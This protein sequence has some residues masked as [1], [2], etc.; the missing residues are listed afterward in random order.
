[1]NE[2]DNTEE[3]EET[4]VVLVPNEVDAPAPADIPDEIDM[5][6][7]ADLSE[8]QKSIDDTREQIATV[9]TITTIAGFI[10]VAAILVFMLGSIFGVPF[11]AFPIMTLGYFGFPAMVAASEAIAGPALGAMAIFAT[12]TY[13]GAAE[14]SLH[15]VSEEEAERRLAAIR[16]TIAAEYDLDA[17]SETDRQVVLQMQERV[18]SFIPTQVSWLTATVGACFAGASALVALACFL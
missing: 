16:T 10:I 3:T 17:M 14:H 11:V 2:D 7:I 15:T 13:L 12:L 18:A 9:G 4:A 5:A 1:M 6:L 8:I